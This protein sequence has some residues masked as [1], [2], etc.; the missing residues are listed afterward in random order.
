MLILQNISYL[1]TN[2]DVL[3]EQI[4]FNISAHQKVALIGNNGSG[5]STLLKIIAQQLSP[6]S[7]QISADPHSYYLPQIY[8]QYNHLTVAQA[9]GIDEKLH[10]F[11][12]ILEGDVADE[13]MQKLAD[14]WTIE[15]RSLQALSYWNLEDITFSQHLSSLSGGQKTKVFLAGI[16]I[17]Q[18]EIVLLDEPSNHLDIESRQ[19]LYHWIE[20]TSSTL[21][22]VS[23]DRKLLNL[24]D[25]TYELTSNGVILYGGNYDFYAKQKKIAEKALKEDIVHQEKAV[26]K[27]KEKEKETSER[28]QKLDARGKKKQEKSGT[29]RIM[30]NTLRNRAENSTSKLK[31]VHQEKIGHL[32][33]KLQELRASV[34]DTDKIKIGFDSSQVH[35]RKVLFS[36]EKINHSYSGNTF[37]WKKDVDLE[38]F[39]GERI[40]L[41]GNNG[42]GKTTLI[43]IITGEITPRKGC[44]RKSDFNVLYIDQDYSLIRPAMNIYD[45]AQTF[46]TS[47]LQEYEVK[48]RLNRFLF[49]KDTWEKSCG[50]LSGGEKMRLLLCCL[51][52]RQQSPDLMILDEPTNNLDIQNIEILTK[53]IQTYQ[54][55]LLLIS[56]DEYFLS[57]VRIDRNI[58]I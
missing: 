15:E 12:R 19:L 38:I 30:M 51:N 28:Q 14:D 34:S 52:I 27:A 23:H 41:K 3:F 48:I 47:N 46:N 4:S 2:K 53:A 22:I 44:V 32:S 58:I 9:L 49:P 55:T 16:L 20:A 39:S 21:I 37:I 10:A 54:G 24:L 35:K 6:A 13:N 33:Q 45:L 29:A 1:H 50:V 8:G 18:P 56:H 25:T 40:A 17:H 11:Y 5:K 57:E 26:R 31:D 7:G 42:S 43:K 36:G